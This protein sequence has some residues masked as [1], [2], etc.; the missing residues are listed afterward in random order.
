MA[1]EAKCL[2]SANKTSRMLWLKSAAKNQTPQRL[3]GFY[4]DEVGR[5]RRAGIVLEQL[6][7]S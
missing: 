3:G 5:V 1:L 4:I 2:N 6:E 7:D